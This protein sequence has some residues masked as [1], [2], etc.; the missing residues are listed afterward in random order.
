MHTTLGDHVLCW[1]TSRHRGPAALDPGTWKA[2][3]CQD[4]LHDLRIAEEKLNLR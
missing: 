4:R 3:G 1:P 2:D